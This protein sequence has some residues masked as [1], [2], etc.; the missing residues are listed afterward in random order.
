MSTPTTEQAP[1]PAPAPAQVVTAK[2]RNPIE[3]IFTVEAGAPTFH[4]IFPLRP[5]VFILAAIQC[6]FALGVAIR[7]IN[8]ISFINSV[9]EWVHAL[10][11]TEYSTGW[12]IELYILLA[13]YI[14]ETVAAAVGVYAVVLRLP[15]YF[16]IFLF[17][18][19]GVTAFTIILSLIQLDG[20]AIFFGLFGVFWTYVYFLYY[21]SMIGEDVPADIES[22]KPTTREAP[23]VAA[24][25]AEAGDI[26][27]VVPAPEAAVPAVAVA[28]ETAPAVEADVALEAVVAHPIPAAEESAIAAK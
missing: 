24:A 27:A 11:A 1:A 21:K 6:L 28:T 19:G 17:V 2:P 22:Q 25:P 23:A 12:K 7:T 20:L 15:E 16:K 5:A 8:A 9:D 4:N 18:S 13:V 10:G 3:E 26:A 14:V